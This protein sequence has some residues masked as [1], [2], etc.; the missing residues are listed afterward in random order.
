[1]NDPIDTLQADIG[2]LKALA[3]EGRAA[4][5]R[6]GSILVAAGIV[7][8]VASVLDWAIQTGEIAASPWAFS[9]VWG[10]AT[11]VFVAALRIIR[12]RTAEPKTANLANRAAGLAWMGVGWTIFTLAACAYLGAWRG[13]SLLPFLM[14]PSVVTALY[15]LGWTVVAAV[16]RQRWIWLTA[17]GAYGAAIVMA[18]FCTSPGLGLLYAGA[19]VLLAVVPGLALMRQAAKAA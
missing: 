7:Y 17:V 3:L 1:M 19:L 4:P 6:G 14:L 10:G 16:S 11:V 12:R 5:W 13:Q 9:W 2:F 18:A 15:G 8:A